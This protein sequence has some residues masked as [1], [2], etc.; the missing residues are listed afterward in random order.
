MPTS[1][2]HIQEE[3]HPFAT[4]MADFLIECGRRARRPYLVQA[5]MSDTNAKYEE[6]QRILT[7][8]VDESRLCVLQPPF[9][10]LTRSSMW[11]QFCQTIGRTL[12]KRMTW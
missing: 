2:I 10:P 3:P 6:D 12:Q 1:L 11:H 5:L 9:P 4:A 7:S 8:L